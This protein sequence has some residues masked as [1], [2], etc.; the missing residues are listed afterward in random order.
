MRSCARARSR[1]CKLLAGLSR[2]SVR[3]IKVVS[4]RRA[5]GLPYGAVVLERLLQASDIKEVVISAYGLREGLLYARLGLRRARQG[6]AG[7]VRARSQRPARAHTGARPRDVPL[8]RA[9]F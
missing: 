4:K 3:K 9:A 6:S 1:L 8:D 7:R 2:E 5:E